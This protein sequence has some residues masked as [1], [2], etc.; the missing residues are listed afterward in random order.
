MSKTKS[1]QTKNSYIGLL[2]IAPWLLGF[3]VFQLYPLVASLY[4]SFTDYNIIDQPSLVGIANYITLFTQDELFYKSLGITLSYVF[5][6]VPLKLIFALFIAMLLNFKLKFVNAY[7][8]VY[9]LPSILGGSVTVAILWRFLFMEDGLLN[10][11]LDFFHLPAVQWLSSPNIALFTISL[12]TVWQFGSSMVLFLAGLKQIPQELYEAGTVDGA[13]K[14]R[15]FFT[16]TVP[17]LTPI[18][19]FNLVLQLVNAFQDFTGPFVITNGGPMNA[20]YLYAMKLYDEGFKFFKMGYASALSW[21]LFMIILGF[22][23]FIFKSAAS[24][25]YY[26]DGGDF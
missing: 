13:S 26:E 15:M 3:L 17:L 21:I 23:L 12:L 18:L 24:W 25:T 1:Y 10:K 11:L 20:T 4:Y 16:I 19:F 14:I 9:Y 5:L 8:T 22:T 6:S 7:R 2:Y